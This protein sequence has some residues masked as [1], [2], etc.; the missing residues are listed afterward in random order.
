MNVKDAITDQSL[1]PGQ[2]RKA[3]STAVGFRG[4]RENYGA[5]IARSE[6][7]MDRF[8]QKW[9]SA[10]GSTFSQLLK[11]AGIR[12]SD[13][14]NFRSG[15]QQQDSGFVAYA[16][17]SMVATEIEW[18]KTFIKINLDLYK[19]GTPVLSPMELATVVQKWFVSVHPFSD[20]N[21]RTSRAIQ[22]IILTHFDMPVIPGGDLQEDATAEFEK[23]MDSTYDKTEAILAQLELCQTRNAST[24]Q[25]QTVAKIDAMADTDSNFQKTRRKKD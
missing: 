15:M 6:A 21:G 17:S 10:M 16:P 23:Y 8:Q 3:T 20:G 22:D 13:A 7:S 18:I 1:K 5:A 12:N 14:A 2:F 11:D 24:F 9:E 4:G 25:C 19:K